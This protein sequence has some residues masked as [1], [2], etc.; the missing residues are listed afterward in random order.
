MD[1]EHRFGSKTVGPWRALSL[2]LSRCTD[3]IRLISIT[4][5]TPLALANGLA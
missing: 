1:L 2:R 5:L 3:V 4:D